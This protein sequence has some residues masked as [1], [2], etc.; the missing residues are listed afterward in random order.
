MFA[1]LLLRSF[2][3][4]S[5]MKNIS[6]GVW[7][8]FCACLAGETTSDSGELPCG[9]AVV[10][11][12]SI[13]ACKDDGTFTLGTDFEPKNFGTGNDEAAG[14]AWKVDCAYARSFAGVPGIIGPPMDAGLA[15]WLPTSPF[16]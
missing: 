9:D 7:L 15:R 14:E 4:L 8:G 5:A 3:A 11:S 1:G 2:S 10:F 6:K 13:L 16:W 12:P